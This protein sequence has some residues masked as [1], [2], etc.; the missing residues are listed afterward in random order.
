MSGN[1]T[2]P[3]ILLNWL[4]K[5]RC[6]TTPYLMPL[7]PYL[8]YLQPKTHCAKVR[9][10]SWPPPPQKKKPFFGGYVFPT[11]FTNFWDDGKKCGM[12][13]LEDRANLLAN[14]WPVKC[15]FQPPIWFWKS[16]FAEISTI[17]VTFRPF[18]FKV[19]PSDQITTKY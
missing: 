14:F 8:T 4:S 7:L 5:F 6:V 1:E 15:N 3:Y 12:A 9:T 2:I 19:Q 13:I 11:F 18:F 16:F 10:I 17:L